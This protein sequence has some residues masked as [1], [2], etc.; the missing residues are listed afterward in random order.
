[1]SVRFRD[2][3]LPA[4]DLG[5]PRTVANPAWIAIDTGLEVQIDEL[6]RP[7]QADRHRTGA[8]YDIPIGTAV[9]EQQY[10]RG[11]ALQPG[12]WNDLEI[13]VVADNYTATLNGYQ[14]A[15]FTNKNLNRG[16]PAGGNTPSGYLGLQEHT[17]AVAFRAIRI[18]KLPSKAAPP[19][20]G[21]CI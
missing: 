21:S 7:D 8:I 2:P 16:R 13:E 5:D 1:M 6:A 15:T 10:Q 11:S 12:E 17:G 14:T 18:K 3:R 20:C 19:P 9:G 4:P